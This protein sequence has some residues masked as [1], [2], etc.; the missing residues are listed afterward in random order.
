AYFQI[1]PSLFASGTRQKPWTT[2]TVNRDK[3][4][5]ASE[6]IPADYRPNVWDTGRA[7][8]QPYEYLLKPLEPGRFFHRVKGKH[9]AVG[10]GYHTATIHF[11]LEAHPVI[12]TRAQWEE[13]V[14]NPTIS[15][16]NKDPEKAERLR[17]FVIPESFI[18]PNAA[19]KKNGSPRTVTI[20]FAVHFPDHV[21]ALV[22]FSRLA[23]FHI[24]SHAQH[25]D[26]SMFEPLSHNWES[27]FKVYGDGPDWILQTEAAQQSLHDWRAKVIAGLSPGMLP[28]VA[29]LNV[30]NKVFAGIGRHLANDLCHH[31]PVH[32]LMPVILVCKSDYLFDLLSEVLP[33][34]M[35][36]FADK[37]NFLRKVAPPTSIPRPDTPDMPANDSSSPFVYKH[38]IQL[39][40]RNLAVHVF[41]VSQCERVG[42]ALYIRMVA[43]GLLD[44]SFVLGK[45]K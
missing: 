16:A 22:D 3:Y 9:L 2:C 32:P 10:A 23:R 44:S 37:P 17:R 20:L 6:P 31:V 27:L 40:Y 30:N 39:K 36:L 41:R 24:V 14:S 33:E 26:G 45:G 34:Y 12:F 25:V 35:R 18:N 29:E 19:P 38:T 13:L 43:Q 1:F 7:R 11:G 5:P 15:G 4:D 28:I 8:D 21:W 42:K